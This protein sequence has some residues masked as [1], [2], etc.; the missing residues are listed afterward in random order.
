M[1]VNFLLKTILQK[2]DIFSNNGN[3][4]INGGILWKII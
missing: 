3:N 2:K 4:N 1:L